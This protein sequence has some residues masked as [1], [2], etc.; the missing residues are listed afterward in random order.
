[1]FIAN[2]KERWMQEL[3]CVLDKGYVCPLLFGYS[4]SSWLKGQKNSTNVAKYKEIVWF[5]SQTFSSKNGKPSSYSTVTR[6]AQFFMNFQT[7]T[8]INLPNRIAELKEIQRKIFVQS[9]Q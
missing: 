5:H 8:Q 2:A 7:Q 3:V 6:F 1:M 4:S 9:I